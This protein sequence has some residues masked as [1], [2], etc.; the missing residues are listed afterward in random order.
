MEKTTG[1]Q[2]LI[3]KIINIPSLIMDLFIAKHSNTDN[4]KDMYKGPMFIV[5]SLSIVMIGMCWHVDFQVLYG[6]AYNSTVDHSKASWFAFAQAT[7]IQFLIIYCGGL[8][9]KILI[10]GKL[11]IKENAPYS[12]AAPWQLFYVDKRHFNQTMLLLPLFVIGMC[13][14]LDLSCKTHASAKAD[15]ANNKTKVAQRYDAK[16]EN[17]SQEQAKKIKEIKSV[18]DKEISD[19]TAHFD[20]LIASS[21]SLYQGKKQKRKAQHQKGIFSA[22]SLAAKLGD[23]TSR[24]STAKNKLMNS[25]NAVLSPIQKAMRNEISEINQKYDKLKE[26]QEY[27]KSR[28]L[29]SI[30]GDIT[31]NAEET[32]GRNIQY[33]LVSVLCMIVLQFF[34]RDANTE[35]QNVDTGNTP[36]DSNTKKNPKNAK[37]QTQ[38]EG[39]NTVITDENTE[40]QDDFV[41]FEI[42]SETQNTE[43]KYF[44]KDGYQFKKEHGFVYIKHGKAWANMSKLNTWLNTHLKRQQEAIQKKKVKVATNN[45]NKAAIISQKINYLKENF[46]QYYGNNSKYTT[47][48]YTTTYTNKQ[49]RPVQPLSSNAS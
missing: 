31:Q 33:N 4:Y 32:R 11:F 21:E 41:E 10:F 5:F 34:Y 3:D 8:L 28:E 49:K 35:T 19:K 26:N 46:P 48:N 39:K 16:I 9:F 2:V 6:I 29:S 20:A 12:V 24:A 1:K 18:Y 36:D 42:V 43:A 38:K 40:T 14:T 45:A 22:A 30:N 15:A 7:V 13:W 27:Q 37:T 25:K 23:Y 17:L 47:S 44:I